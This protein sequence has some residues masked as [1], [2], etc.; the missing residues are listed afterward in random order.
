M[1]RSSLTPIRPLWFVPA[2]RRMKLRTLGTLALFVLLIFPFG[3]QKES[4]SVVS[5]A[6]H[7]AN[8]NSLYVAGIRSTLAAMGDV[9]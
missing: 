9:V 2:T 3:C 5:I 4:E 7:P 8:A 6:L 1:I